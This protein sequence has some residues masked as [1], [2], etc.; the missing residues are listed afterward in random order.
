[1]KIYN[2]PFLGQLIDKS[3][4]DLLQTKLDSAKMT[5]DIQVN[6]IINLKDNVRFMDSQ[7][8]RVVKQNDELSQLDDINLNQHN[9]IMELSK[10]NQTNF[11]ITWIIQTTLVISFAFLTVAIWNG[12]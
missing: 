6:E 3:E 12:Y 11:Y 2:I 8:G 4:I 1:M 9:K 10:L 5:I 7:I